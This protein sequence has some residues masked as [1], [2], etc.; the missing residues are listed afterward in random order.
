MYYGYEN[1][2]FLVR[3]EVFSNPLIGSINWS[4]LWSDQSISHWSTLSRVKARQKHF[5]FNIYEWDRNNFKN[6]YPVL[7]TLKYTF[8]WSKSNTILHSIVNKSFK[9]QLIKCWQLLSALDNLLKAKAEQFCMTLYIF[10][11]L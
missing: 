5:L 6:S 9:S 8:F 1:Q 10:I 7:R 3:G 4:M 2:I 11:R